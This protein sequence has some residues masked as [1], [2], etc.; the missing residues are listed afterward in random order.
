MSEQQFVELNT[1][2]TT[3]IFRHYMLVPWYARAG[4]TILVVAVLS[5][6][7]GADEIKHVDALTSKDSILNQVFVKMG[8]AWTLLAFLV[9]TLS[10][11]PLSPQPLNASIKMALRALL[12]TI[13][14]Y[15][16]CA[17][18]FPSIEHYT[19]MCLSN[20]V[21]VSRH[22]KKKCLK[23]G[24]K[25][26]SFD[27]S[28]HAFL[29]VY[30]VLT[31]MQEAQTMR[32]YMALGQG[33]GKLNENP[34]AGN[35]NVQ[36][37]STMTKEN[38]Q[39]LLASDQPKSSEDINKV[40]SS[41]VQENLEALPDSEVI[42]FQ[43]TYMRLWPI[44]SIAYVGVCVLCVMWDIV[45]VIT[46]IYYHTLSEKLLGISIAASSFAFLYKYLFIKLNLL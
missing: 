23:S 3:K 8:W 6:L 19:G 46:T 30:C 40:A 14:F 29:M 21:V 13:I 28:G 5:F 1:T 2:S 26:D 12:L 45:L 35:A 32:R 9:L 38:A 44:V 39:N 31:I 4:A 7:Q 27:I 24:H 15:T 37:N 10:L 11:L 36:G 16:W 33:I 43:A 41:P 20:N 22:D 25:F 17:V 34:D 18:I 42:K